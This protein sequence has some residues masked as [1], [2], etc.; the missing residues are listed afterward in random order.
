MPPRILTQLVNNQ[1]EE[2]DQ[3]SEQL[4][5]FSLDEEAF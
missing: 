4:F 2:K 1:K 5:K 3:S